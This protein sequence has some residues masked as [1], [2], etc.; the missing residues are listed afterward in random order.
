MST[1]VYIESGIAIPQSKAGRGRPLA[2]ATKKL[3]DILATL[4][5]GDSFI[6]PT[7]LIGGDSN[8]KRQSAF[9][10]RVQVGK[11]QGVIN[12]DSKFISRVT[13]GEVRVWRKE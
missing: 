4:N 7:D 8:G 2:P 9:A 11:K 1:S 3:W 12:Q 10:S 13:D 5:V 6:L